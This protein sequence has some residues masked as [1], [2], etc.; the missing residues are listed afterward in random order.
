[1]TLSTL[2]KELCHK[3]V[4]CLAEDYDGRKAKIRGLHILSATCWSL[5]S[6][7]GHIIFH[8]YYL[9]IRCSF[10]DVA[11]PKGS[12]NKSWNI[13]VIQARLALLQ[14]KS[15]FVREIHITDRWD[16]EPPQDSFPT[17]FIPKLLDTLRM[18]RVLTSIHLVTYR[19]FVGF[20]TT[21]HPDLWA[22]IVDARPRMLF[23]EGYFEIPAGNTLQPIENLDTLS[24]HS[25]TN[26]NKALIDVSSVHMY[27]FRIWLIDCGL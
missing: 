13:D 16:F 3:I 6:L 18:L 8:T 17:K 25:C 11:Y 5:N 21:I 27:F 7:C 12:A 4:D 20:N 10:T 1:M 23:L 14:T 26:G 2:P 19:C 24:V 15:A 9:D 22:W